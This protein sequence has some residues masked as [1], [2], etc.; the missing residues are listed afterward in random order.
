MCG[1]LLRLAGLPIAYLL[2]ILATNEP[3]GR[4]TR[5]KLG[6]R[7][8]RSG[9]DEVQA[10]IDRAK[11]RKARREAKA[12]GGSTGSQRWGASPHPSPNPRVSIC[13]VLTLAL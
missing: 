7:R 2:P 13:G 9:E 6:G 4:L 8:R 3:Q 12:A 1:E 10:N 5:L 11:R